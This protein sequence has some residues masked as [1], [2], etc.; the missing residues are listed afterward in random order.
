MP[1]YRAKVLS[2]DWREVTVTDEDWRSNARRFP[3]QLLQLYTIRRFEETL[4]VLKGRGLVYGPVHSSIGQEA[5]PV[6][7]VATLSHGDTI[8]STHR[9]HHHFLARAMASVC[10]A[11]F[12]PLG[13]ELPDGVQDVVNR[14]LAEV[15]GLAPGWCGGRGGSM[16]LHAPEL[17]VLGT[18][19]IV[20]GGVAP[21]TGAAWAYKHLGRDDVVVAFLGDGAVNQGVFHEA[22]NLGAL[23]EAPVVYVI[24]NNG[25]A[26]GTASEDAA[27]L[28]EGLLSQRAAAY[29]MPALV[30]DGMDPVAV[31]A[32][33][34]EAVGT[35][36]GGGHPVV[37][38]ALTYRFYHHGGDLPGHAFGYR[39][40]PEEAE[41]R[42]RDPVERFPRE[43]V[44][45][46]IL[47]EEQE[48]QLR[49]MAD[50]LVSRAV[51]Y[52]TVNGAEVRAEL[53]PDA[54]AVAKGVRSDGSEFEGAE[55]ARDV[56]EGPT[57]EVS[58]VEAIAAVTGRRMETDERVF[59]VGEE[60]GHLGGGAYQATK[61]LAE[62]FPGR[63]LD[64]PISEAGFSGFA[65]GAAMAGLRPVVEIMFPDFFLV[66]A[67]QVFNH[68]GKLRHMYG[69]AM[70]LPL[71]FR[72]RVALGV[73]YGGQHSMDPVALFALFPG[74][75]VVAPVTPYDYIGM[76]NAAMRCEDPVLIV[77]HHSL[78]DRKGPVPEEDL[79]YLLPLDR[80][81]VVKDGGE[82]TVL[83]YGGMVSRI[84]ALA[85]GDEAVEV[86]DLRALDLASVDYETIGR[87]VNK[88]G[89]LVIADE[90]PRSCSIGA[91]IGHECAGRF[92]DVLDGPVLRIT[93]A[94]VPL[95]VSRVLE[96]AAIPSDEEIVSVIGRAARREV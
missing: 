67:D 83:A 69:G 15:M 51:E 27:H 76:F 12:D 84:E 34:G 19:A 23:W 2:F 74:W 17:G 36:R 56:P 93:G 50:E 39:E 22:L 90:A 10:P 53:W 20:A 43:L 62:R 46:K 37:V 95:P 64:T 8:V 18:S 65:C 58:Y 1:D 24:E 5:V 42:A 78:Y 30:V 6:G 47:S 49:D 32:A 31:Q 28:H 61:G 80:A 77:E 40:K 72:T 89:A 41:W 3:F 59:V 70:A 73:G 16:H 92:F 52:C 29:D 7:A 45:R 63:V 87:S 44:E 79:D 81:R 96:A 13:D 9:A 35:L 38:E 33:V 21:A 25:Y 11:E 71:V 85:R 91:M 86:V 66:A 4:F 54:A 14:T 48:R 75:R 55:F 82:V 60:V 88:T 68:I 94:D 57:R 26:V